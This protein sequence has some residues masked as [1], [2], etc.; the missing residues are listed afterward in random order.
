M[1]VQHLEEREVFV[2]DTPVSEALTF[3]DITAVGG[4]FCGIGAED[5][6]SSYFAGYM[7][8]RLDRYH[9]RNLKSKVAD[10]SH[11]SDILADR[12]LSIHLF[13]SF[14]EYKEQSCANSGLRYCSDNF[15][16]TIIEFERVFLFF[17]HNYKH[18]VKFVMITKQFIESNCH[19]PLFCS[20]EVSR[21]F[22]SFYVKCRLFQCIKVFNLGLIK[23]CSSGKVRK[24][25]HS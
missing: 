1:Q 22:I 3:S 13:T 24:I 23:K 25:L 5:G 6:A 14:K 21:F 7:A 8:Y 2:P 17:F 15:I 19:I 16:D 10:C 9:R 4:M 11:C 12:D 18:L 20:P